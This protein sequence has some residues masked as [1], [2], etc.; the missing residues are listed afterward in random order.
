MNSILGTIA[1]DLSSDTKEIFGKALLPGYWVLKE[2]GVS[3]FDNQIEI[4]EAVCDTTEKYIAILQAR[5]GGKTYATGIALVKLCLENRELQVGVFAPKEA[6]A[7]RILDELRKKVLTKDSPIYELID[8][9]N[10]RAERI[11]FKNGSYIQALSAAPETMQEGWHFN[12]AVIDECHQVHDLSV[13]QRIIPMLGGMAIGKLIKIGI[14]MYKNNFWKSCHDKRYKVLKRDW[15]ECTKLIEEGGSFPYNGREL[16]RYVL[17]QMPLSMKEKMFPDR[18]DLHE[19]GHQSELEFKVSYSMDW[20]DDINLELNGDDQENLVSGDH[21]ILEMGRLE[22]A[23]YYFFGLD[24]AS[25]S[26]TPGKKDLDYTALSIWRRR[27]DN[28]KEKVKCYE[29]QGNVVDQ[30]EE[31]KQI[32]HPQTGIFRCAFGLADY[33]NVGIPIVEL[34]K[35]ERIPIEG[36]TF[37]STESTSKKNHKNA[38]FDEF[39]FELQQGRVKFP[40]LKKIDQDVTFK[41]SLNE[42]CSIERIQKRG[43]NSDIQAPSDLHDDHPC[44]DVLAVWAMDKIANYQAAAGSTYRIPMPAVGVSRVQGRGINPNPAPNRYLQE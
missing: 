5:G 41:K 6:Q 25:G 20:I 30:M 35:K 12:I 1:D 38:M 32:I 23:E 22:H 7:T 11:S 17:D 2:L 19:P 8:W 40:K 39:K 15:T 10:S 14:S 28:V 3:L 16:S 13:N 29:W 18:P 9:K 33:S 44:A 21:E 26:L 36:I 24:T 31:I 42:W 4:M 43:I 27:N 34:F 37:G